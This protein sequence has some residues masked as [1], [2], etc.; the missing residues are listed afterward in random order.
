VLVNDATLA[1]IASTRP[2]SLAEVAGVGGM[3]QAAVAHY[4]AA[5]VEVVVGF[6]AQ[7]RHLTLGGW[8]GRCGGA[9]RTWG[10]GGGG[11]MGRVGWDHAWGGGA[12]GEV[13]G[14]CFGGVEG[15][16]EDWARCMR[17]GG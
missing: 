1:A 7:A 4:G 2:A 12:W 3:G 11:G 15:G 10:A 9:G 13:C 17:Q 16:P 6:C 14:V 8:Q 5:L